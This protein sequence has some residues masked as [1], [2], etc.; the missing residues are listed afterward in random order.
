[1]KKIFAVSIFLV[2]SN[3][4]NTTAEK[5]SNNLKDK[6]DLLFKTDSAE[7]AQNDSPLKTKGV[8]RN[9]WVN[10]AVLDY[11]RNPDLEVN[12]TEL[13]PLFYI[14]ETDEIAAFYKA[15]PAQVEFDKFYR[16]GNHYVSN[17]RTFRIINDTL[18]V[19]DTHDSTRTKEFTKQETG[20]IEQNITSTYFPPELL[21]NSSLFLSDLS[22]KY[23]KP[24][25]VRLNYSKTAVLCVTEDNILKIKIN[26]GF[27]VVFKNKIINPP[28][29][30]ATVFM[31]DDKQYMVMKTLRSFQLI[32]INNHSVRFV[33]S[34][35]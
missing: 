6:M 2:F 31:P 26:A 25:V 9:I 34:S 27:P 35:Y 10:S 7:F 19:N 23:K 21:E 33:I 28:T 13:L 32:D 20:E 4:H 5:Q 12:P 22:E 30:Y 11:I 17:G 14:T 15:E 1:M 18:A 16:V 3:C 24:A 29:I 8:A